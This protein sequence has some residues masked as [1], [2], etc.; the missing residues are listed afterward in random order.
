MAIAAVLAACTT[1]TPPV[2]QTQEAADSELRFAHETSVFGPAEDFRGSGLE[3]VGK[4]ELYP[5]RG[6]DECEVAVL[7]SGEGSFA[8]RMEML[9]SA[10][11]SIRIQALVFKGDESGLRIA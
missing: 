4:A 3:D 7:E 5:V 10:R 9:R 8:A 11:Q 6:P 2:P 1:V